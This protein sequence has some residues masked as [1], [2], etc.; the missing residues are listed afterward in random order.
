[1]RR[2]ALILKTIFE[3]TLLNRMALPISALTFSNNFDTDP[4]AALT[5]AGDAKWLPSGGA[6][7]T[8]YISLDRCAREA[9]RG[10]FICQTWTMPRTLRPSRITSRSCARSSI[11]H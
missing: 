11:Q 6:R 4:S 7:G 5:L 3:F 1:M 8:G 2:K 9:S 10:R